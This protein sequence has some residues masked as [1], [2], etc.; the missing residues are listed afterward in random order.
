MLEDWDLGVRELT[1]LQSSPVIIG[2]NDPTRCNSRLH[3]RGLVG[4]N[5]AYMVSGQC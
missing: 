1:L 3:D 4:L 2:P 5:I